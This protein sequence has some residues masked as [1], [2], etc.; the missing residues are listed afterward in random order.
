MNADAASRNSTSVRPPKI[1]ER[2]T[3]PGAGAGG[4][5]SYGGV[6][7]AALKRADAAG[8]SAG[9]ATC[10]SRFASAEE[11][12]ALAEPL[13]A[14]RRVNSGTCRRAID[15]ELRHSVLPFFHPLH[16]RSRCAKLRR[17]AGSP[18][19]PLPAR[20]TFSSESILIRP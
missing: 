19:V 6:D 18:S 8:R 5:R 7:G 9:G 16:R 14:R 12:S 2:R 4:D 17:A 20:T 1:G 3:L 13:R 10:A 15:G 11:E